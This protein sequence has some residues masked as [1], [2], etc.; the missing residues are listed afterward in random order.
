MPTTIPGATQTMS[1]HDQVRIGKA[2]TAKTSVVEE[3]IA[4]MIA[5]STGSVTNARQRDADDG[6]PAAE[7][8]LAQADHE[9]RRQT[10]EIEQK[11]RHEPGR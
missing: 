8:A 11:I 10:N 9:N 3:T 4:T 6:K 2:F 1:G 7:R 5:A